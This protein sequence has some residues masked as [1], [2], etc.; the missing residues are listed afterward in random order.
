MPRSKRKKQLVRDKRRIRKSLLAFLST[1]PRTKYGGWRKGY[2]ID[3]MDINQ[4]RNKKS[5]A[6]KRR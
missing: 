5:R 2:G 6:D 3:P 1:K 4:I